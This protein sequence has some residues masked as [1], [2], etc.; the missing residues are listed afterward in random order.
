[1]NLIGNSNVVAIS[2]VILAGTA[3]GTPLVLDEALSFWG[4]VDPVT[5]LVIDVHHPQCGENIR[6]SLLF[7]PG[8][9]GST[10]GPGALLEALCR[11]TGPAAIVL[12]KEDVSA[13]IAVTAV[14]YLGIAPIPIIEVTE[15]LPGGLVSGQGR[16]KVNCSAMQIEKQ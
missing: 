6:D 11:G 1:M 16:W 10:A 8:T 12:T 15:V 7:L 4:G 2:R 3:Q 9:R 14:A 13:L 5:G